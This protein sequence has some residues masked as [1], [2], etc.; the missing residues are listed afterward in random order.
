MKIKKLITELQK[1]DPELRVVLQG[2]EGGV[3]YPKG[4]KLIKIEKNVNTEWYYGEHEE[5]T[6]HD[7]GY[8]KGTEVLLI[9]R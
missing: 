4:F 2:Y 8:E 1:Y 6:V 5:L 7:E 3:G 9:N